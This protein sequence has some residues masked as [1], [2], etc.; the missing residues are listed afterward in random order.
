MNEAQ[1]EQL[2]Q[3]LLHAAENLDIP[4]SLYEE[5]VA[6]YEGVGNWLEEQD[7]ESR[8]TPPKSTPRDH[9]ASGLSSVR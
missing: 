3:L 4:D 7:S 8:R 6:K 1:R 5:A 9:F 2:G